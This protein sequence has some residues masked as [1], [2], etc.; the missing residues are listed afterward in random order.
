LSKAGYRI[1]APFIR[2]HLPT[3]TKANSYF[4]RST[5]ARDLVYF[6][7]ELNQSEP[8]FFIAQDGGAAIGYGVLGAFP[9]KIARAML[10]AVPHLVEINRTLKG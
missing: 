6:I 8:V 10:L 7:N 5:L 2:G 9:D 3:K 4:D 1:V